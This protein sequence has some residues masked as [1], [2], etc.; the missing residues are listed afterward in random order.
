MADDDDLETLSAYMDGELSAKE[1]MALN[2]RLESDTEL[3]VRLSK[4]QAIATHFE[5]INEKIADLASDVWQV[6]KPEVE[7]SIEENNKKQSRKILPF[8]KKWG[9][10]S[11]I[12]AAFMLLFA[13]SPFIFNTTQFSMN[14]SLVGNNSLELASLP[15]SRM[16]M[17][18]D[19]MEDM[20]VIPSA[21]SDDRSNQM[22]I[23]MEKN[24]ESAVNE[25]PSSDSYLFKIL[26][27]DMGEDGLDVLLGI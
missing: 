24:E 19:R 26:K 23:H 5:A 7:L 9:A 3:K 21:T 20:D 17:A 6:I 8:T 25:I 15:S 10:V 2:A 16:P 1:L 14:Q 27:E 4:L 22:A 11:S 12:A 18:V 13:A